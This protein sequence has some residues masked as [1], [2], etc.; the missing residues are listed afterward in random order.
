MFEQKYM[1]VGTF[2]ASSPPDFLWLFGEIV[3][4][5]AARAPT[6]PYRGIHS[7]S[8]I[9]QRRLGFSGVPMTGSRVDLLANGSQNEL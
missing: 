7:F 2:C 6:V 5:E 9:L 8:H 1:F 4:F 3:S